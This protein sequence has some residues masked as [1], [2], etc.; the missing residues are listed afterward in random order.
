MRAVTGNVY[1]AALAATRSS[2]AVVSPARRFRQSVPTQQPARQSSGS[3][4]ANRLSN[5]GQPWQA[6]NTV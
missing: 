5:R 4:W 1:Q 3:F 6:V 2:A